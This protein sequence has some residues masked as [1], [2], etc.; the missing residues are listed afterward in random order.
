MII[1]WF[2]VVLNLFLIIVLLFSKLILLK[3]DTFVEVKNKRFVHE[4]KSKKRN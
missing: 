1:V 3:K 2:F 4:N